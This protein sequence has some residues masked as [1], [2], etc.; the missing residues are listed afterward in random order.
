MKSR[1]GFFA[2][3]VVA[4]ILVGLVFASRV[5]QAGD[6]FAWRQTVALESIAESA[7]RCAK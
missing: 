6:G 4:G 1:T 7:K 5:A 2:L 3:G